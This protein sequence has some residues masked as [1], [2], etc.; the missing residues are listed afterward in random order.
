MGFSIALSVSRIGLPL[1][2]SQCSVKA[3]RGRISSMLS[4]R[5]TVIRV[6]SR[7]Q[8]HLCRLLCSVHNNETSQEFS[9]ANLFKGTV[10]IKSFGSPLKS[11]R[12]PLSQEIVIFVAHHI[13]AIFNNK[14]TY[15]LPRLH[16]PISV[17]VMKARTRE[18]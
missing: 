7:R 14:L 3:A 2:H 6:T 4:S 15:I 18:I 8:Y 10:T 11:Y 13:F 1:S 5:E 9:M 16:F 17:L 12:N